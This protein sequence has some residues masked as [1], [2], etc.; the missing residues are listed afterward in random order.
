VTNQ[1]RTGTGTGTVLFSLNLSTSVNDRT[2]LRTPRNRKVVQ[3]KEGQIFTDD[4]TKWKSSPFPDLYSS[5]CLGHK[6]YINAQM[7]VQH[8]TILYGAI[9]MTK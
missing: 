9:N 8:Y 6:V 3:R 1:N 2:F 4:N 7:K 5:E